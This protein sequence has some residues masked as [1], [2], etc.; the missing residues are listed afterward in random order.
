MRTI[1]WKLVDII[2][3]ILSV[4]KKPPPDINVMVKFNELNNLN[5][6]KFNK[7]RIIKLSVE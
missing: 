4:G 3:P 6:E 5:P 2:F 1:F 7:I